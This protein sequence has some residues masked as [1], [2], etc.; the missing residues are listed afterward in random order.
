MND[1]PKDLTL[2]CKDEMQ[3]K[4]IIQIIV[5][6]IV[7]LFKWFSQTFMEFG[8]HGSCTYSVRSI[9]SYKF[10]D[11]YFRNN[12]SN[13][14]MFNKISLRIQT[15]YS[16]I[17]NNLFVKQQNVHNARRLKLSWIKLKL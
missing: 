12:I 6:R 17:D 2:Q 13:L 5:R 1:L 8:N 4:S 7:N 9:H 10:R 14:R 16:W 15:K 3:N 11:R